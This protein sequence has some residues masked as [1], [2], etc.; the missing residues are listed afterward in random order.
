M[1]VTNASTAL[2]RLIPQTF[3]HAVKNLFL[4]LNFDFFLSLMMIEYG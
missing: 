3:T 2:F 1:K 4:K